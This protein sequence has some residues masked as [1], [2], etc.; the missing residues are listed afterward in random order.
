MPDVYQQRIVNGRP[1]DV[2][3]LLRNPQAWLEE[4]ASRA[5]HFGRAAGVKLRSKLGLGRLRTGVG[6]R[7]RLE[8]GDARFVRD[9]FVIPVTW[10]ASGYAGLFP[11]MDAV[12][13]VHRAGAEQSR[14]VFWGRYDP[15]LG[16]AGE[17]IDRYVAHEV[18]EVTVRNLLEAFA[19]HAEKEATRLIGVR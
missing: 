3:R 19:T 9:H 1:E 10:E 15:P 8:V 2:A 13:E 16:R 7:A 12:M 5:A 11:V 18:A 17:L 14:I 6:K 4:A